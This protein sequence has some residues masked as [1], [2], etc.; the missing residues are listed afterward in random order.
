MPN[1][2]DL[3]YLL[4]LAVTSPFWAWSLISTGKWRTDWRGR[5]GHVGGLPPDRERILLHGV[6]VGETNALAPLVEALTRTYPDYDI[7]VSATTNTGIRQAESIYG[8]ASVVRFPLDFSWMV[9]RFLGRVQPSLVLL[10]E[11]EVWPNF[12]STCDTWSI[13]VCVVNGRL[14]GKGFR[15]YKGAR[16]LVQSMFRRLTLVAA[17]TEVYRDRFVD[18]GVRPDR[19]VVI[20][21]LKWDAAPDVTEAES[22]A[23][24]QHLGIDPALPLIVAGSTG[25]GEEA[26]LI[27]AKPEGVQLLLAPRKPERFD[28]VA[29]LLPDM[30]RRSVTERRAAFRD[31]SP[32]VFLLDTIGELG[33]A[34][35]LADAVFVGRSLIPLGGSNPLEP[36]ALGKPTVTGPYLENFQEI[37]ED[38]VEAGGLVVS[39]EPMTVLQEWINNPNAGAAV[40][41][42]GRAL[43]QKRRG[44]ADRTVEA[45]ARYV[46]L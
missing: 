36:A 46:S 16:A 15:R 17:Q 28:E 26:A 33:L 18:L 31:S 35:A 30:P 2:R 11:L 25:P 41:E 12:L 39:E 43:V 1:L 20:P 8:K 5:F 38:L 10:A 13:P 6:S 21:P 19:C 4:I 45:V 34:Y 14:S 32:E 24:Q 3:A 23:L 27:R 7:V 37:A 29:A 42:A 44:A 40:G 22:T 9:R